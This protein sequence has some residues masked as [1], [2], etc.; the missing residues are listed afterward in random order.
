MYTIKRAAELTGVPA[1]TLRAWERRYDLV[2]PERTESGY[3][4]YDDAALVRRRLMH[5]LVSAGWTARNAADVAL[6]GSV[7]S[8]V[9]P[10]PKEFVEVGGAGRAPARRAGRLAARFHAGTLPQVIEEW[11]LPMLEELGEAWSAGR[12]TVWQEHAV[13]TAVLRQLHVAFE[14]TPVPDGP[15]VLTGLPSGS[16]HEVGLAAFNLMARLVGVSVVYLGP[17]LPAEAWVG[18]LQAQPTAAA[19]IAVPTPDDVPAARRTLIA[20]AAAPEP[21]LLLAGGGQQDAVADLARPLGH[22]VSA[23]AE[24]LAAELAAMHPK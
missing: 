24:T 23:A 16:H 13:A 3:R 11:L 5:R 17:D 8:G 22:S 18:A 20:L 6:V 10:D 7:E 19:V 21:C 12:I 1:A 9:L 15:L 2:E 4:L 14:T